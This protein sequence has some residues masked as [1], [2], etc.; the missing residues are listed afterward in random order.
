M[1]TKYLK[2]LFE[3]KS[4]VVIGASETEGKMGQ[5]VL[6][7]L[8]D[9][10]YQGQVYALNKNKQQDVYGVPTYRK[11]RSL[12]E[13][14]DL[15]V[16]CTPPETLLLLMQQLVWKGVKVV[17]L[18]TGGL[19]R[20]HSW[21]DKNI[22]Q[23][24]I[25]LARTHGIRVVGPNTLGLMS[26]LNPINVG[27]GHLPI[28]PGKVAYIGQSGTLASTMLDWAHARDFGFSHFINLDDRGDVDVAD[29]VDYLSLNRSVKVIILHLENIRKPKK[30]I[31][32]VGAAAKA[33]LVVAVRSG[34]SEELYFEHINRRPERNDRVAPGIKNSSWVYRQVFRRLGVMDFQ[35]P[36]ALMDSLP[37][38]EHQRMLKGKRLAIISNSIGTAMVATD[39]LYRQGSEPLPQLSDKTI[40]KLNKL[41]PKYWSR[42]NPVDLKVGV[43]PETYL[44]VAEAVSEDPS[45]DVLLLM[46]TP[47]AHRNSEVLAKSLVAKS[48]NIRVPFLTCWLGESSNQQARHLFD[49]HGIPSFNTPETAMEAFLT[50]LRYHK[51]LENLMETPTR[52]SEFDDHDNPVKLF[53][54]Y[55]D[56]E[57]LL[58]ET[59]MELMRCYGFEVVETAFSKQ[60]DELALKVEEMGFPVNLTIINKRR[61]M[62][63]S[64]RD[65][66]LKWRGCR[67]NIV[68]QIELINSADALLNRYQKHDP[69]N[70]LI[71]YS[72]QKV[73]RP[74]FGLQFN[75]GI[76]RDPVFGPIIFFG[77]GGSTVNVR[78][79]RQV[80]LPPLN[81]TLAADMVRR[82]YVHHLL[83]EYE[84]VGELQ[85]KILAKA[86][87]TLSQIAIEEPRLAQLELAA[88][89]HQK[90][91][92]MIYD[93]AGVVA[94]EV[95]PVLR[96][97]PEHLSEEYLLKKSAK[98]VTLRPVRAEDAHAMIQFQNSISPEANRFRFFHRQARFSA[99]EIARLTQI[100][101][102]REMAFVAVAESNGEEEIL[103]EVRTW[104]DP[105][106]VSAEFAVMV[107]DDLK[108]EGLG[109]A[110]M[111]KMIRYCTSEKTL[112]M[113]G[114][115]LPENKAMLGL[116]S[117]LGFSNQYNRSEQVT[118]LYMPL[119]KP[120]EDWQKVR[121][122]ELENL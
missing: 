38:L 56:N 5:I 110:L 55:R 57:V 84:S 81:M 15:A 66:P 22:N 61:L 112:T 95:E 67:R 82:S 46:H 50:G 121:V 14:P 99:T 115:V 45:V 30:F 114:T 78:A 31:A 16:I 42:K 36:S 3:P 6:R 93:S 25:H 122:K 92:L 8:L 37:V 18:L 33:K 12:P 7:N 24:V 97:Y 77:A 49:E 44:K 86:L 28:K 71:C 53:K 58:P 65:D 2:Y 69:D 106:H 59:L 111:K 89:F 26:S 47:S 63:F 13:S 102:D 103:G 119:N 19:S 35:S 17:M 20:K 9:S 101:Y 73:L 74:S 107:R 29:I 32:A 116:A 4:V 109:S 113:I 54:R 10:G 11:V 100:D 72:A 34:E 70:E 51:S 43:K 118:E 105:D 87:V 39:H 23:A 117:Y 76:T 79:D 90:D 52:L 108:G 94:D 98:Q 68:D 85:A 48:N 83:Q 104:T 96:A 120:L 80:G 1:A 75:M 41:L 21:L 64:Y 88:Q 40:E 27:Y 62:P 60:F 91:H